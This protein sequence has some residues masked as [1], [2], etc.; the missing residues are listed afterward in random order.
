MVK[1]N[2]TITYENDP[3]Q[4]PIHILKVFWGSN[5]EMENFHEYYTHLIEKGTISLEVE[6]KD[7]DYTVACLDFLKAQ[8]TLE[9]IH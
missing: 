6:E 5:F 8:Y 3:E 7:L 4:S 2:C 1:Y 9:I